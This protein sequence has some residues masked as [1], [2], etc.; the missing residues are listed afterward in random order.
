[1]TLKKVYRAAYSKMPKPVKGALTQFVAAMPGKPSVKQCNIPR[2]QRFPD[3]HKAAFVISADFEMAWA[4]RYAKCRVDHEEM[5]MV[6][7]RNIPEFIKLF[8]KYAIPVTWATVGHLFLEGCERQNGRP[9]PELRRIPYFTNRVWEFQGGD[10]YDLDPCSSVVEAPAWYAP[11]LIPEVFEGEIKACVKAA[12][13]F[14]VELKSIVFP[15]GTN[16]N[17]STLKR[18][19]FTNYR[20]NA[21]YDL[22][23]PWKDEHGLWALPSSG[24]ID[25]HGFGWTP[26][27]YRK[28]YS[29]YMDKAIKTG[30]VCH[31][32]FHP[33]V[34]AYCLNDIFPMVLEIAKERAESGDLWVTTM[35]DLAKFCEGRH[36]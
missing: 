22:F 1:M 11:D 30:T 33:S 16:G 31:L 23:Y 17:Y 18:Y 25:D 32:W 24:S 5:G 27:Y 15:G 10:W 8:E 35:R 4:W 6:E 3:G 36:G 28:Y 26:E 14:G 34:N 29:R 2:E 21:P 7:R 20:L 19:G 13:S 12:E 9:H